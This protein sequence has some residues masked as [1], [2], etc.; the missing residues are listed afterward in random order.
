MHLNQRFFTK[1]HAKIEDFPNFALAY[2]FFIDN[3]YKNKY[4]ITCKDLKSLLRRFNM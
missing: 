4:T 1:F 3:Y 2:I